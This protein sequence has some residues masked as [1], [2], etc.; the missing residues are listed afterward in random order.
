[1]KES[2]DFLC[3]TI[4]PYLKRSHFKVTVHA[5]Y[6]A[7]HPLPVRTIGSQHLLHCQSRCDPNILSGFERQT[8]ILLL[9]VWAEHAVGDV[10]GEVGV[11]DGTE[12]KAIRPAAAEVGYV[13]ILVTLCSVLTPA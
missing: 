1:M 4:R 7:Q 6:V 12:R 5:L 3:G 10:R 11:V 9:I 8:E 13:N 2:V